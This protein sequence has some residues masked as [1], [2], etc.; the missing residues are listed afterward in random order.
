[1]VAAP[2]LRKGAV[3]DS[4][5]VINVIDAEDMNNHDSEQH[6]PTILPHMHSAEEIEELFPRASATSDASTDGECRAQG[7]C[8]CSRPECRSCFPV[9]E[10]FISEPPRPSE[11]WMVAAAEPGSCE[12]RSSPTRQ[13]YPRRVV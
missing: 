4:L 9:W 1:M 5:A 10:P 11:A 2:E 7:E 3:D 12:R 8:M 13:V 6:D